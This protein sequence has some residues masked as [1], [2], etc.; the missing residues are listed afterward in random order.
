[1][2]LI[3][4]LDVLAHAPPA[5]ATTCNRSSIIQRTMHTIDTIH[6]TIH[7]AIQSR[8]VNHIGQITIYIDLLTD[9]FVLKALGWCIPGISE[10]GRSSLHAERSSFSLISC[11]TLSIFVSNIYR[12]FYGGHFFFPMTPK[13]EPPKTT[14]ISGQSIY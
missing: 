1:M 5:R 14:L 13:F 9:I 6:T 7:T 10:V 12:F 2:C 4:A 3:V 11:S 8:K